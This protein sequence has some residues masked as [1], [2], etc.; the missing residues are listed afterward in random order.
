MRKLLLLAIIFFSVSAYAQDSSPIPNAG[1][2]NQPAR[3][4][5]AGSTDA[6][7][8][9]LSPAITSYTT[10][11]TVWFK[12]A[13]ANTGAATLNL[14]SLGAKT[15]KKQKDQ[16]LADNDIKAGQWV[17]LSYDGTNFQMLSP[18]SNAGGVAS[19]RA[20]NT[21]SPISGG[22]DLSQIER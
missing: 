21:T 6:Y 2:L 16:D 11:G 10:G 17:S 13:T 8:C 22:G 3:C 12:A 14:N 19:T 7:A 4:S 5:D 20:I 18:V 15:I 9:S 1:N